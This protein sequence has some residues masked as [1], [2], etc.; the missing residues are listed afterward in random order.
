MSETYTVREYPLDV[1]YTEDNL[2]SKGWHAEEE[3]IREARYQYGLED[4]EGEIDAGDV[5]YETWRC[6]PCHDE[7]YDYWY[8]PAQLGTPGAFPVTMVYR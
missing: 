7:D 2:F 3:F 4:W 1:E 5:Y 6:V 8:I